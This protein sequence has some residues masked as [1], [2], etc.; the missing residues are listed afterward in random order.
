MPKVKVNDIRIHYEMH[1][2][3][4]PLIM[5]MGLGAN[6]DWWDSRMVQKL[7]RKFKLIMFDNRGAGRTETSQRNYTIR[8][9]AED[10]ANLVDALKIS[11]AHVIGV[12]MGGMT[13]Q[14]LALNYPEKVEKLVLCSTHCGGARAIRAA[15]KTLALSKVYRTVLSQEE[16]A[17]AII[18]FLFTD[19][20]IKSHRAFV[21][22]FIKRLL[23]AP[24]S[25]DAFKR[26]VLAIMNFDACNR[27]SQ[28]E[29]PTLIIH[30]RRDTL[31]PPENGSILAKVIPNSK[32][33]YLENSGHMLSEDMEQLIDVLLNFLT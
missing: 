9:F 20:F 6:L 31:V 14:E 8:L 25:M 28:I 16:I 24:I 1:G 3:G 17:R 32:L 33:I 10:T 30:G 4:F 29:A 19:D 11:K 22:L 12:S 23:V 2:R 26:Q 5:L 21:E 15:H 13:A 18:P 7:S 27:L